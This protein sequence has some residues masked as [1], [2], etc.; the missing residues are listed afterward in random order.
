MSH[1]LSLFRLQQ[2]DT[3]LDR[4]QTRLN[5]IQ[6]ILGDDKEL[7]IS[8]ERV[9]ASR[10]VCQSADQ[11]LKQTELETRNQRIKIEQTEASLYTGKGHSPKELLDLQ[12]DIASL[13]R[14]LVLLEDS[15][16]DAMQTAEETLSSFQ[17]AQT[18]F[19][20]AQNHSLEQNR[21]L[22]EEQATLLKELDKLKAERAA[23]A[24]SIP[25][26]ALFLYDTLRR[27]RSGLAV[28]VISEK[29]CSACGSGLS[30]AQMQ[31]SRASGEMA[32]C[33]SCGRILYGS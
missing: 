3:Q 10:T 4:V 13:K 26:D 27:E 25:N 19:Q 17:V 1:T 33:P 2:I 24:G 7:Q 32:L 23:V 9:N 30:A 14:Y 6:D 31:S 12:N 5:K 15:E 22:Q 28:A 18:L 29:S 16:L 8:S 20:A 21:G 11:N